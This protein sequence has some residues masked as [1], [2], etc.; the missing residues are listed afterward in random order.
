M[1][2]IFKIG[3]RAGALGALLSALACG[4][5]A[6]PAPAAADGS[7]AQRLVAL[8]DYVGGDYRLAVGGGRI[9]KPSEY[10]EQ[11]RFVADAQAMA[12]GLLGTQ[13]GPADSLLGR[14]AA[15]ESLVKAKAE[16]EAVIE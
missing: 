5:A 2:F 6:P 7:D 13:A 14:L 15:V 8:M 4:R 11:I 9:L 10:E 3:R 16:P 1:K 12:R